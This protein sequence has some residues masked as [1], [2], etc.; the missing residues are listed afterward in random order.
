METI[1]RKINGKPTEF[2]VYTQAEADEQGIKYV[3]WKDAHAEDMALSDDGY[4]GVCL[5]RH[6][7]KQNPASAFINICYGRAWK[8]T[9][10]LLF[11]E[12]KECGQFSQSSAGTWDSLEARRVRTKLFVRALVDM[13]MRYQRIDWRML[14]EIYR[15]DLK[16]PEKYARKLAN[17]PE[18]NKMIRVEIQKVLEARGINEDAVIDLFSDAVEIAKGNKQ[19]APIIRVAEN[20][21]DMLGMKAGDTPPPNPLAGLQLIDGV[22]KELESE[23]QKQLTNGNPAK[24]EVKAEVVKESTDAIE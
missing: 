15:P 17:N 4:V 3:H 7:Y 24:D 8:G 18:V 9:K 12:R 23:T 14:G 22:F 13:Y 6:F 11:L 19:P 5:S 21:S 20:Y 1:Q 2:P 16:K 10:Q